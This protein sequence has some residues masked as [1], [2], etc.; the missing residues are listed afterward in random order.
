MDHHTELAFI[1]KLINSFR[2]F[3]FYLDINFGI[4]GRGGGSP[5]VLLLQRNLTLA[6]TSLWVQTF[7]WESIVIFKQ[8]SDT[9]YF[10]NY[11]V[12]AHL[13]GRGWVS[14]Y[15][16]IML[17]FYRVDMKWF[18]W[19]KLSNCLLC[20]LLSSHNKLMMH[21]KI[22]RTHRLHHGHGYRHRLLEVLSDPLLQQQYFLAQIECSRTQ[23]R[24]QALLALSCCEPS[25][26]FFSFSFDK[27]IFEFLVLAEWI[28]GR[29]GTEENSVG[30]VVFCN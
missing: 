14:F 3:R 7:P 26:H 17:F 27:N 11:Q 5:H 1:K 23:M 30:G 13:L 20:C 9:L 29:L 18:H 19:R 6:E 28:L 16:E 8:V 12:S 4:W 2:K 25:P 15:C 10:V 22:M 21:M 24:D